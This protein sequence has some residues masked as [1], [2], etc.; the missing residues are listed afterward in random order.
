MQTDGFN[1]AIINLLITH[2]V[3]LQLPKTG[4]MGQVET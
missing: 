1:I 4:T 2:I 3:L